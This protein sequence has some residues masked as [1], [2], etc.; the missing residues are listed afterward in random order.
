MRLDHDPVCRFARLMLTTLFTLAWSG[1]LVP[2]GDAPTRAPQFSRDELARLADRLDKC[3]QLLEAG[4]KQLPRDTFDLAAVAQQASNDPAK[5]LAFVRDQTDWVPYQGVLRGPVGALMDRLG[6]SLDRS[7][8][9]AGLLRAAGQTVRLAHA[10][11]PEEKARELMPKL[12]TPAAG[13][14]ARASAAVAS[15]AAAQAQQQ[16]QL[17]EAAR[18][19]GLDVGQLQQGLDKAQLD[20][21]KI[22]E[23]LV[24]RTA[25]QVPML[26]SLLARKQAPVAASD[27]LAALRDH[28]WVQRQNGASW[29]DLDPLLPDAMPGQTAVPAESTIAF[30]N[31]GKPALDAKLFH[32]LRIRVVVEQWTDGNVKEQTV[33][34]KSL[35]PSELVG[36]SILLRHLPLDK[37]LDPAMLANPNASSEIRTVLLSQTRWVPV[38]CVGKTP[39]YQG[40]FSDD[41]QVQAQAHLGAL[42]RVGGGIGSGLGGA[43]DVLSADSH[44]SKPTALSAEWIEYQLVA[45]G[46]QDRTIRR[47]IF[48]LLG[49][50]ARPHPPAHPP[51]WTEPQ[52]LDRALAIGGDVELLPLV[53]NLSQEFVADMGI[54]AMLANRAAVTGLVKQ[55]ASSETL[56]LKDVLDRTGSLQPL[57]GKLYELALAR[58][59]GS[60]VRD[61]MY[62]DAVNVLSYHRFFRADPNANMVRCEAFDVVA[63]AV[64]VCNGAKVDPFEARLTQGVADT[65]AEAILSPPAFKLGNVADLAASGASAAGWVKANDPSD[66]ALQQAQVPAELRARVEQDLRAGYAV[67]V[68][69]KTAELRRRPI[70]G[71][72]RID[73]RTGEALGMGQHGWGTEMT[74]YCML[75]LGLGVSAQW[76]CNVA[77]GLDKGGLTPGDAAVC[78][79]LGLG[80]AI[81]VVVVGMTGG[82]IAAAALTGTGG[83]IG[84]LA[85]GLGM[86]SDIKH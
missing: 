79:L 5:L 3:F 63:N 47:E 73:P 17:Q 11:L 24:Q 26:L 23:D 61:A 29:E 9:L 38:L 62:I 44:Q 70:D 82:T 20:G 66:P 18:Q 49:P 71:W 28:W 54:R 57:P 39:I 14:A 12:R 81:G 40:S 4:A 58:Q 53:C 80:V 22:V 19:F 35:R 15:A 21:S 65:N 33:L 64:S 16:Q 27:D 76:A 36:E 75:A 2:A 48:D 41:G 67:I 78:A 83:V 32:E 72:W 34:E 85:A 74:E 77:A 60:P 8:L 13:R 52:R 68:P 10:T 25:E 51:Q 46:R 43:A 84:A 56:S 30:D 1:A 45:P 59:N 6:N 55:L 7:L 50:A 37:E 86:N 31:D 42:Q 69:G